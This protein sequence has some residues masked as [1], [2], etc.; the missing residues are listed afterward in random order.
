MTRF[1]Y[2]TIKIPTDNANNVDEQTL[3]QQLNRL[4]TDG[5]ELVSVFDTNAV[6]GAS[7]YVVAIFKRQQ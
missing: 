1:E 5:W 6:A 4:G 3:D 7:I 2:K